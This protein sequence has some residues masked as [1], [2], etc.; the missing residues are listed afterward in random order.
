MQQKSSAKE[1]YTPSF[2]LTGYEFVKSTQKRLIIFS[3][4]PAEMLAIPSGP[5]YNG[6][7]DVLTEL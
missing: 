6:Y 7:N 3:C 2:D 4:I 1:E 5:D